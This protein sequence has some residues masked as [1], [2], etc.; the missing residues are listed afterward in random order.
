LLLG[1][2]FLNKSIVGVKIEDGEELICE[3]ATTTLRRGTHT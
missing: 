1:I 2:V 3:K